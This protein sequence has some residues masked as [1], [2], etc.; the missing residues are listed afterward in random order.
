M[1][2]KYLSL[3]AMILIFM[4][5]SMAATE[6]AAT[7]KYFGFQLL[8]IIVATAFL[9]QKYK[10]EIAGG[11]MGFAILAWGVYLLVNGSIEIEFFLRIGF[12]V[13]NMG[14]C[15]FIWKKT[16]LKDVMK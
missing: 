11:L 7:T 5:G 13:L 8:L 12:A 4:P 15:F 6:T 10:S 14:L 9:M 16:I 3:L 1:I 2:K